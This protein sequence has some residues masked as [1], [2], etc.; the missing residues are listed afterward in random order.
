MRIKGKSVFLSGPMSDDERTYHVADFILAHNRVKRLG[1]SFVYD[2][3]IKYL[4][5]AP[6]VDA[7]Q[8][9]ED[10]ILRSVNELTRY[11]MDGRDGAVSRRY[12][13]VVQLPGWEDSNGA[14]IECKVAGECDIPCVPLEECE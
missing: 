1:A 13:L 10:C 3:A 14:W 12:D 8:T 7:A 2:P 5:Q 9:Y 6:E 4:N 11:T